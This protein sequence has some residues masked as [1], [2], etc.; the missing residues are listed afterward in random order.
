MAK[1]LGEREI[2]AAHAAAPYN[3]F[4]AADWAMYFVGVYGQIDGD[5]HKAWVLDAV[6]RCLNDAPIT[7]KLAEWDDG[8]QEYRISV[9]TCPTYEEWVKTMRG[10]E[11]EEGEFE[12]DYNEGV[13]P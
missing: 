6:A 1:Y 10:A 7:I 5:H 13:P 3:D 8:T 4:N 2:E 12:Y 9:G 11:D